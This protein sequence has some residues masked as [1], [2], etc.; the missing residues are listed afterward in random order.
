MPAMRFRSRT[1][2]RVKIRTPGGK[3]VTHYRS[4]KNSKA[5]CA[6]CKAVLPGVPRGS[7]TEIK[8]MSKSKRRPERPFGGMFCSA[9]S[10]KEHIARIRG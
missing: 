5:H 3:T 4:R 6:K 9:C 1:L 8:K 7:K 10:R 2:R